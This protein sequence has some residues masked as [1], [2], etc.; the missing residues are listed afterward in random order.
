MKNSSSVTNPLHGQSN[1]EEISFDNDFFTDKEIGFILRAGSIPHISVL[2]SS[3]FGTARYR[4]LAKYHLIVESVS[5]IF[6]SLL[7]STDW[8]KSTI[9]EEIFLDFIPLFKREKRSIGPTCGMPYPLFLTTQQFVKLISSFTTDTITSNWTCLL[10]LLQYVYISYP[11]DHNELGYEHE[12]NFLGTFEMVCKESDITSNKWKCAIAIMSIFAL[13]TK[14]FERD[15]AFDA[16]LEQKFILC[17]EADTIGP[18]GKMLNQIQYNRTIS[19]K[20]MLDAIL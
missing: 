13:S 14:Y 11:V 12:R 20:T 5:D 4:W 10:R 9:P 15:V 1:I 3:A 6:T 7:L 8:S 17:S 16:E 18:A 2:W 19:R